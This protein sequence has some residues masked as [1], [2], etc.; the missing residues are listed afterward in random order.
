M[1]FIV[2]DARGTEVPGQPK[3]GWASRSEAVSWAE[4]QEL[5]GYT[6]IEIQPRLGTT[7]DEDVQP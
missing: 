3:T 7:L 1:V 4:D 5:V 6:V 2:L